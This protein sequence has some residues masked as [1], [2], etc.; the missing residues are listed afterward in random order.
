MNAPL[1]LTPTNRKLIALEFI[2]QFWAKWNAS[3]SL[4]EIG[5]ALNTTPSHARRY[6]L[7]LAEEQL[8]EYR[9]RSP[10]GITL[11]S[12]HSEALRDLL[13]AGY[14]VIVGAQQIVPPNGMPIRHGHGTN[15]AL[16]LVPELVHIPDL[17]GGDQHDETD[18]GR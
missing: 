8:I 2:R 10:R 13:A 11:P 15:Y 18:S 4:Q 7:K 9:P 6:V 1:R 14:T 5:N 17:Q 12:R 3:P 16:T